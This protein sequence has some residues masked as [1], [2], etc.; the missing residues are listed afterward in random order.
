M[1]TPIIVGLTGGI[2]SGKS[3]VSAHLESLGV[4]VIDADRIARQVVMPGEPALAE[5]VEAFGQ[6]VLGEDGALDRAALGQLIFEDPSARGRLN[7]ITHPRI[8]QRMMLEAAQ[9][10]SSGHA[11]VV[12]DA[13]LLVENKIYTYLNALIVVSLAPQVQLERLMGRDNLS[14]EQAQA[15]INAQ[16]PL[17]DKVAVA[18]YIIDNSGDKAQTLEKVSA[19]YALI[20]QAVKAQGSAKPQ[21]AVTL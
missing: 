11:W 5:I 7:S 6:G 21:R 9:A 18:D 1:T 15:R 16:L 3:T 2:A 4:C 19:L 14:L 17:A 10:F 13:A 20:D 12:Y 8:A